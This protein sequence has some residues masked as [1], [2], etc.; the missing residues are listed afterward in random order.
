MTPDEIR[1]IRQ[2]LGLTQASFCA[3]Y[4]IG[5]PALRQWERGQYEPS[6]AALT[7]LRLIEDNPVWVAHMIAARELHD[8]AKTG[9]PA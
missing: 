1:N 2:R 8:A 7:L 3:A 6:A 9:D 4:G 5:L